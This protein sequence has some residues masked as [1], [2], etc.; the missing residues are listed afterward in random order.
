MLQSAAADP[1]ESIRS[2]AS[3]G[4]YPAEDIGSKASDGKYPTEASDRRHP[5]ESIHRKHPVEDIRSKASDRRHSAESIRSS[6]GSLIPPSFT[7]FI[8]VRQGSGRRATPAF[9]RRPDDH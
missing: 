6:F 5:A 4:R 3:D 1:A 8:I 2:K 7:A 9:L